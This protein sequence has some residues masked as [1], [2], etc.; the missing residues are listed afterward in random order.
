MHLNAN[1]QGLFF[2]LEKEKKKSICQRQ[3]L[4]VITTP[5]GKKSYR[6]KGD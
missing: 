1:S 6:P 5:P 4:K 2:F 3:Y